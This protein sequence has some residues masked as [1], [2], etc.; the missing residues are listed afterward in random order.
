VSLLFDR[1]EPRSVALVRLRVGLG[2][3]LC[4]VP[5]LRA[6]R[7]RLP[8]ARL[9]LITFAEVGPIVERLVPRVELLAFPGWPGIPERPPDLEAIPA[10]LA[11]AR[12]E[13]FDLALQAYGANPA[14]NEVTAA[15][16]ARRVGGFF[17][18]GTLAACPD[19]DLHLPYPKTEHEVVRHLALAAHLGAPPV[20]EELDFPLTPQD[21]EQATAVR[22]SA[23][24]R[25]GEAYACVHPGATSSSRRWP[26]DSFAAVAD[27][28][29][30]RGLRVL[31]T[32]VAGEEERTAAVV[33]AMRHPA[34]DLCGRTTL[35]GFAALLDRAAL[36]VAS[37][38]G[39][40]HLAA[41]RRVS[42][43]TVFLSGDPRRWSYPDRR[44]A[45]ARVQVECN[46]CHHLEC[47]IDHRCA[48]RLTVR[49]VLERVDEVLA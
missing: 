40:A 34:I 33:G 23:G 9:V 38:T 22:S 21:E 10:F 8:H 2:D 47:P 25:D 41:A 42:S 7:A 3:L 12:A 46:P 44:H 17:E 48:G 37:D 16:G 36:L 32:G 1:D 43:V 35:G 31:V 49:D 24:L 11:A 14:A 13:R 5:A 6:L 19:L 26:T 4:T 28:L 27:A 29:A 20:G 39:A 18:P 30:D 45:V 15:L